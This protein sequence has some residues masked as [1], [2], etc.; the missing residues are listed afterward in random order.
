VE[1]NHES[2]QNLTATYR[3]TKGERMWCT[4]KYQIMKK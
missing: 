1:E 3:M 2:E 4:R